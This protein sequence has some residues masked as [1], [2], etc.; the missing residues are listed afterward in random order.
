MPRTRA[1]SP[2]SGFSSLPSGLATTLPSTNI[3]FS[4]KIEASSDF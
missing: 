2:P 1:A 4:V 3:L